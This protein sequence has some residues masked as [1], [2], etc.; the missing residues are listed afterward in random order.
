MDRA[1][2]GGIKVTYGNAEQLSLKIAH[3]LTP[4]GD[5][6]DKLKLNKKEII[7]YLEQF[8]LQH[9]LFSSQETDTL[10]KDG[11]LYYETTPIQDY[12]LNH[13]KDKEYKENESTHGN[14]LLTYEVRGALDMAL[15]SKSISTVVHRHE[16]LHSTFHQIGNRFYLK[17]E[18]DLTPYEPEVID[19]REK[20][21]LLAGLEGLAKLDDRPL[22][23]LG[24]ALFFSRII[25]LSAERYIISLKLHHVIDDT[26]SDEILMSELTYCYHCFQRHKPVELK[27]LSFQFKDYLSFVNRDR[28]QNRLKHKAYWER[29]YQTLPG[30]LILPGAVRPGKRLQKDRLLESRIL[31]ITPE[32]RDQ[33]HHLSRHFSTTAFVILQA[34]LK[35]FIFN[36]T[37]QHDILIGTII[38]G[39]DHLETQG[40]IGSYASTALIRT[41]FDHADSFSDAVFKVIKSN[42]DLAEY[43]A[44]SLTDHINSM[45]LPGQ[46]YDSFWKINVLYSDK[47]TGFYTDGNETERLTQDLN[48]SFK[49]I[50][51][52]TQR[53]IPI[54]FILRFVNFKDKL[55]LNFQYDSSTYDDA[56]VDGL[57]QDY[58][59]YLHLVISD[60]NGC[61]L[62]DAAAS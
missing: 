2:R 36:K 25:Q 41:V 59:D 15:L 40:Q 22:V 47:K 35:A 19:L 58:H 45:L 55:L 7:R 20:K 5:L 62:T 61:L 60:V 33:V 49:P 34:A 43:K 28:K 46:N 39:R 27:T 26:W 32:I 1:N 53:L 52:E 10:S 17:V 48:L 56:Y 38:S 12:W 8:Q 24:G 3:G 51:Q 6:I 16:S 37:R 11:N 42:Q 13:L 9:S 21:N 14:I 44:Y 30:P 23:L 4:A 31:E 50:Y 18:Q 29:L 54:D 57:L